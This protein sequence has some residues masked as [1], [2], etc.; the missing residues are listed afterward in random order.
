MFFR[1]NRHSDLHHGKRNESRTAGQFAVVES[2]EQEICGARWKSDHSISHITG[3]ALGGL[4]SSAL[5]TNEK[6]NEQA[7]ALT[8]L[9]QKTLP[10]VIHVKDLSTGNN[11]TLRL[12]LFRFFAGNSQQSADFTLIAHRLSEV[13]LLPVMVIHSSCETEY[14]H[15]D[16][17]VISKF[18]GTAQDLID[19]PTPAQKI[20]FGETRRRIPEFW[21]LDLPMTTG[22]NVPAILRDRQW[23][24]RQTFFTNHVADLLQAIVKE[25]AE[26]TGRQHLDSF[27]LNEGADHWVVTTEAI[28]QD[29]SRDLPLVKVNFM[30]PELHKKLARKTLSFIDRNHSRALSTALGLPGFSLVHYGSINPQAISAALALNSEN[31]VGIAGA[32]FLFQPPL[33]PKEEIYNQRISDLYNIPQE[34]IEDEVRSSRRP[35]PTPDALSHHPTTLEPLADLHSFW[36]HNGKF[37]ASGQTSLVVA[38]PVLATGVLPAGSGKMFQAE[39]EIHARRM[40]EPADFVN[41]LVAFLQRENFS[42]RHLD[43]CARILASTLKTLGRDGIPLRMIWEE[44]LPV[45]IESYSGDRAA[46][47]SELRNAGHVLPAATFV[48][49]GILV[50]DNTEAQRAFFNLLPNSSPRFLEKPEN[51]LLDKDAFQSFVKTEDT[52]TQTISHLFSAV[53]RIEARKKSRI[54]LGRAEEN[55]ARLKL[56]NKQRLSVNLSGDLNKVLENLTGNDLTLAEL[57]QRMDREQNPVDRQWLVHV[58]T[59]L[60][61]L[62]TLRQKHLQGS[63]GLGCSSHGIISQNAAGVYP[64]SPVVV[65]WA[66]NGSGE[67]IELALGIWE[68]HM[69]KICSDFITLRKT[70][71]ELAGRYNPRIH[72]SFF[73]DFHWKQL[74]AEELALCPPLVITGTDTDFFRRPSALNELF[75]T[76]APIKVLIFD[77]LHS[78]PSSLLQQLIAHDLFVLQSS[79][80]DQEHLLHGFSAGFRSEK[81]SIFQILSPGGKNYAEFSG[82]A[83]NSGVYPMYS[84]T[85][86]DFSE[87]IILHPKTQLDASFRAGQTFADLV[88]SDPSFASHFSP[89]NT[90]T[91]TPVA[92]YLG[93]DFEDR[94]ET[95]PVV[96]TTQSLKVSR[97]LLDRTQEYQSCKALLRQLKGLNRPPLDES[98]LRE[99]VQKEVIENVTRSL[100]QLAGT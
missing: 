77:T 81:P 41:T 97:E 60:G 3:A 36:A 20:L 79:L 82:R 73:Q 12:P 58:H 4:R 91:G 71:L 98:A 48:D 42:I 38:T 95:V 19:S 87:T 96:K 8:N 2:L 32:R 49:G 76:G 29:L 11:Q 14:V 66:Q 33:N 26:L 50:V 30:T 28:P 100:I 40:V 62:D 90:L 64:W 88:V 39:I 43:S 80:E 46:L 27:F 72:D 84:G 78:H 23:A 52:S 35:I 18:L 92:D 13:A 7:I 24:A 15:P 53:A 83:V 57:A 93:L 70:E 5:F 47:G 63:I 85:S 22:L 31:P 51:V 25:F 75:R 89:L 74:S 6:L 65:P 56:H 99:S 94:Q 45:V 17:G 44:S 59:L 54:L 9:T 16:S 21:N 69:S 55:L 34:S 61:E 86:G 68:A 67:G 37:L 10:L 1:K